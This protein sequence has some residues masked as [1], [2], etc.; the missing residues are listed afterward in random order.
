MHWSKRT[1]FSILFLTHF[2]SVNVTLAGISLSTV[3]FV[4]EISSNFPNIFKHSAL[5]VAKTKF[6]LLQKHVPVNQ[7]TSRPTAL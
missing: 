2:R 6:A 4:T 7:A 3:P 1:H 5:L